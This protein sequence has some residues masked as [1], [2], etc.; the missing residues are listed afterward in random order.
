[1]AELTTIARPYAQAVFELGR[2]TNQL[3]EWS[4]MLQFM[5]DVYGNPQVQTALANPTLTR[6]DVERL[7]LAICG[8]RLSNAARNLLIVLVR[9][10]RLVALPEISALYE[11][12]KEQFENVLEAKIESAYPLDEAQLALLVAKLQKRTG[13]KIQLSVSIAPTLIGG[14]KIQIGDDVWDGSIR[15]E[16][17]KM[18]YA[19]A[20]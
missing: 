15:G 4:E 18:S 2:D 19:L 7:L 13:H 5:V 12:L 3:S 9:N 14:V 10:D 17:E 20:A 16:L 11:G 6:Q 8:E 1:M